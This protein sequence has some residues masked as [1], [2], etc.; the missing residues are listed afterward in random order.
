MAFC[1]GPSVLRTT[2]YMPNLN[3]LFLIGNLTRDPELRYTPKGTAVVNCGIAVNEKWTDADGEKHESA[4]FV[5]FTVW[6][7]PAETFAQYTRQGSTVQLTGRLKFEAWEQD[8]SKR[9]KLI[10]VVEEFQFLDRKP[11]S[12]KGDKKG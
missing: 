5:D 6:G 1:L 7:K 3:K 2:K 10:A 12:T 9:S 4:T 8:G 11:E